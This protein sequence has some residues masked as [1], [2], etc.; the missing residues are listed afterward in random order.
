VPQTA[1]DRRAARSLRMDVR[2]AKESLSRFPQTDV[3]LPDP[4]PDA[5][6][7]RGEVEN[8]IRP[9]VVRT[10]T[11][12]QRTIRQSERTPAQLAGIFLVGGSSRIPLVAA[13]IP[14]ARASSR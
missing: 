8:L 7:T 9:A 14:T 13:L 10:V 3:P 11:Q 12:L 4:F 5:L 1:A 2:A 6:L